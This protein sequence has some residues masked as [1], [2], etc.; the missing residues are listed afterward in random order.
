MTAT[1]RLK[2]PSV[3]AVFTECGHSSC[4][5][6]S[7]LLPFGSIL[8]EG[9]ADKNGKCATGGVGENLQQPIGVRKGGRAG[10]EGSH[11]IPGVVHKTSARVEATLGGYRVGLAGAAWI[12]EAPPGER[13]ACAS[14]VL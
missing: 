9:R 12:C 3:V 7:N 6:V 4:S 8:A 1:R 11:A 5:A 13:E 10:G 2:E 14:T